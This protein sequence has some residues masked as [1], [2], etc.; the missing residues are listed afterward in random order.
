[1]DY[2][3]ILV[4]ALITATGP[5]FQNEAEYPNWQACVK[6]EQRVHQEARKHPPVTPAQTS[7]GRH[8]SKRLV[9]QN[10]ITAYCRGK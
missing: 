6:A 10:R 5:L 1:M 9:L 8:Q 3:T 2:P 4:T 7:A